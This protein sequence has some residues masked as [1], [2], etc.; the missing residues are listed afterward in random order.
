MAIFE[1]TNFKA[2]Y[3]AIKGQKITRPVF[4]SFDSLP[5]LGLKVSFPALIFQLVYCYQI[6]QAQYSLLLKIFSD[7]DEYL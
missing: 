7:K 2:Y 5:I 3:Y 1:S 6:E 4:H